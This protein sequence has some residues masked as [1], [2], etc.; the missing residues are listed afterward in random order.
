MV[1]NLSSTTSSYGADMDQNALME[2]D[3]LVAVDEN[4]RVIPRVALSKRS[5]HTFNAETPRATL[6]RAF[7][8]FLFNQDNQLLLTQRA[9]DKITFPNVW[10]NTVENAT[11]ERQVTRTE[12]DLRRDATFRYSIDHRNETVFIEELK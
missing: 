3:M 7:S 5:G 6:H 12:T 1:A 8:F 11:I 9:A 4:D 10:T 2:S